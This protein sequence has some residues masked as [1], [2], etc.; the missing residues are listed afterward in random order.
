MRT[1]KNLSQVQDNL[2]RLLDQ[3]PLTEEELKTSK[4]LSLKKRAKYVFAIT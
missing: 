2:S 1:R 4:Q 3:A